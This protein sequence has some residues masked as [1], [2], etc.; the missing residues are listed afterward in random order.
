MLKLITLFNLNW[1]IVNLNQEDRGAVLWEF[2]LLT[3]PQIPYSKLDTIQY[4]PKGEL[5]F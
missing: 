3:F 5:I 1:V 4:S 2:S